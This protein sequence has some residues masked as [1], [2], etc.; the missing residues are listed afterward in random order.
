MLNLE[1]DKHGFLG[2][3]SQGI[4]PAG[5]AVRP[6]DVAEC[7]AQASRAANLAINYLEEA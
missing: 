2:N 3:G 4:F 5:A 6:M 7:V 1:P